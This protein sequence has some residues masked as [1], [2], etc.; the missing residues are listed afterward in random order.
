MEREIMYKNGVK[1]G[2]EYVYDI[3]GKKR[4]ETSYKNNLKNGVRRLYSEN[5]EMLRE[6]HYRDNKYEGLYVEY[7]NDGRK[8]TEGHY[9]K[10]EKIGIWKT[11]DSQGQLKIDEIWED[12]KKSIKNETRIQN[13]KKQRS[14]DTINSFSS[15]MT[16]M[17]PFSSSNISID[18]NTHYKIW[19][20][21]ARWIA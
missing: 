6:A 15:L 10:G 2:M 7:K 21:L 4:Q 20:Y 11:Y 8:I 16:S 3:N 5:E 9:K 1:D 18:G 14:M 13:W 12:G 19:D 17:N